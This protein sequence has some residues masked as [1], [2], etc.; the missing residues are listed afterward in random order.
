MANKQNEISV[1]L[2]GSIDPKLMRAFS[3]LSKGVTDLDKNLNQLLRSKGLD[4]VTTDA[5]EAFGN[6]KEG[7]QKIGKSF[8]NTPDVVK[9][10]SDKLRSMASEEGT[11]GET[12]VKKMFNIQEV[13]DSVKERAQRVEESFGNTP[14]IAKKV[15]DKLRSMTSEESTLD[16]T[17]GAATGTTAEGMAQAGTPDAFRTIIEKLTAIDVSTEQQTEVVKTL[18]DQYKNLGQK[19]FHT[20]SIVENPIDLTA[21]TI[22]QIEEMKSG[23]LLKESPALD[24]EPTSG[25][26]ISLGEVVLPVLQDMAA[27]TLM[28]NAAPIG[29]FLLGTSRMAAG[30]LTGPVGL[31]LGAV[32]LLTTGI[33]AYQKHQE[34]TRDQTVHIAADLRETSKAYDEVADRA[35]VTNDLVWEYNKLNTEIENGVENSDALASKKKRLFEITQLLQELYPLTISQHEIENGLIGDKVG[36]LKQQADGDKARIKLDLENAVYTGI[37]KLPEY[38][39]NIN[40]Y[41]TEYDI[42]AE[43][44][45]NLDKAR[46]GLPAFDAEYGQ[47]KQMADSEEKTAQLQD[48]LTRVSAFSSDLG[49][50]FETVEH[51]DFLST[52]IDELDGD[53][54]D[55]T[56]KLKIKRD[57]LGTAKLNYQEVYDDQRKLI[58]IDLGGSLEEYASKYDQ[59]SDAEKRRFTDAL[60]DV[61]ELNNAMNLLEDP[62]KVNIELIWQQTGVIPDFS[63]PE[64]KQLKHIQLRDPGFDGYAEGGYIT[65]PELAWVGEGGSPEWIIPENNSKRS[66]SLY[67][68]AGE[69]LGY[70]PGGNFAPVYS[71]QIIIKGQANEQVIRATLRDSQREW[72]QNMLGWQRQQQRRSLV[73]S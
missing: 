30:L 3:D 8:G 69:A 67:A 49:Y 50:T 73:G 57:E 72:E 51:L 71:P 40:K 39:E 7:A 9:R 47:I 11:L 2:K 31:A 59:L 35:K 5:K 33:V 60:R 54:K 63:T 24:S 13:F 41:Q 38:E 56:D 14:D 12:V 25:A 66:H 37:G 45:N 15:S 55:V 52:A 62:K 61:S 16:N 22:K 32:G 27:A 53:L 28:E 43:H 65:S 64:G 44:K 42:L 36:L 48:L 26:S 23:S 70:N 17:A 6:L 29:K 68:A 18:G 4:K 19:V 21:N 46:A 34:K 10:V 1:M 20:F 58:E